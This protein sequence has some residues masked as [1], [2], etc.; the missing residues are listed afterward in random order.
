MPP[1]ASE[2]EKYSIDEMM[3]RLKG[4]AADSQPAAGELVTRAD[5]SQAL[6]V[7]KRKRRSEQPERDEAKRS[8]HI[9]TRQ[10]ASGLVLLLLCGLAIGSAYVYANTPAYRK[11]ITA[12][13]AR[14]TGASVELRQFRVN[15][16][17]AN[18]EALTLEWP[19]GSP[20]RAFRLNGVSAD[21]SVLGLFVT[22]L[23]GDEV[24][25]RDGSL[26][27]QPVADAPGPAALPSTGA[28]PVQ[29]NTIAVPKFDIVIGEATLPALHILATEA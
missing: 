25:A 3:E 15:P 26:W 1:A 12:A 22:R 24:S 23:R 2:P 14:N 9:R 29:F 13:I 28:L 17:S 5:G 10:V 20:L 27:L 6:R 21:V 19:A 11:A 18:V 16:A 4:Q 8:R 7:R